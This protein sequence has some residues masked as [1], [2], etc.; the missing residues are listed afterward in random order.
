MPELDGAMTAKVCEFGRKKT[1][2]Q[3]LLQQSVFLVE[4]RV[5]LRP[6][7]GLQVEQEDPPTV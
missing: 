6:E 3:P 4:S 7:L 2:G 1:A 5:L